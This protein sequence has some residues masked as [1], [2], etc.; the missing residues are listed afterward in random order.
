MIKNEKQRQR[1]YIRRET[2]HESLTFLFDVV[3][4]EVRPFPGSCY[5][6]AD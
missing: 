6:P 2:S 5:F 3:I 1:T 4:V